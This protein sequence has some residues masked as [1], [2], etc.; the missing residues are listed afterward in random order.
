ML[1]WYGPNIVERHPKL[2]PL[3]LGGKW[4]WR[5]TN[6][7]CEDENK[8]RILKLLEKLGGDP[9]ANF[10]LAHRP[11][12]LFTRMD[13][14]TSDGATYAPTRRHRRTALE[15][16]LQFT[17]APQ[18]KVPRPYNKTCAYDGAFAHVDRLEEYLRDMLTYKFV[19]SPPGNGLDTHRTWEALL[20]GAIPVVESSPMDSLFEGLPVVIL[21][22]W[23]DMS[24]DMLERSYAEMRHKT[25]CWGKVFV[26]HYLQRIMQDL[27]Q[28]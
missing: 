22:S 18:V 20:M 11:N 3:P 5:C 7:H 10:K 4:N 6:H 21:S 12:L 17:Q 9:E 28:I 8:G 19:L 1:A 26:P 24:S 23:Q 13:A 14:S 16:A 2:K 25:Y 15:A 27:L